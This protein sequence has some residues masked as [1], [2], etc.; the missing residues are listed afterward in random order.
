MV[1][2]D[3][4]ILRLKHDVLYEVAKAAWEGKLEEKR[5][6]I[7]YDMIPGPQAATAAVFTRSVRSSSRES[8]WQKASA[9]QEETVPMWF[10]SLTQPARS[11]PLRPILSQITAASVWERPARIP[12][13]LEPSPW[14]TTMPILIQ[15]SARSAASAHRPVLIMRS[16][17]WSAPCKKVCPVDAITYDEYG[18]CVIDEKKCIQCGACI[19][20][21]PF[22]AIGSKT[23]M[24]DVIRLIKA[25]KKV[26][27]WWR[28]R[29]K[30]SSDRIS[31]W[32]AGAWP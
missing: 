8:V 27:P 22:G 12:V 25:G 3:A 15:I 5:D 1:T 31:P 29:R 4:T 6:E 23:F 26:S 16:P 10:R 9:L 7:P 20:S 17:I 13:I 28:P 14:V 2:N 24:V 21:C 32:R 11:V 30:D 18:I 19:H